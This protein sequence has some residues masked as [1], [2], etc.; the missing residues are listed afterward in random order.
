MDFKQAVI[1]CLRYKY[2]DFRGRAGKAEFWWFFLFQVVL[3][4]VAGMIHD[5]VYG[6]VAL[7]LV[8]PG[9]AVG[10]RRLHD[11]GK[12]GWFLLLGLIPLVGFLILVYF[13]IQPSAPA[14]EWGPGPEAPG[15][16]ANAV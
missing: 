4:L 3:L 13:W 8:L 12:S 10:A 2:A 9:L 14:N 16:P 5:V 1:T 6:V 15:V 7:L 11:V